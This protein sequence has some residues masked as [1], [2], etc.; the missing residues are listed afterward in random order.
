MNNLILNKVS[1]IK[2][3]FFLLIFFTSTDKVAASHGMGGEIT[4]MCQPNGS[5]IFEIKFYRDCNG[6]PGPGTIT[7]NTTVPGIPNIPCNF[8]SQTDLSNQGIRSDGITVCLNCSQ[9]GLPTPGLVQELVYRS[10]PIVLIGVPPSIGWVFFYGECCRNSNLTNISASGG[11]GYGYRAKM[12]PYQGISTQPCF[13]SSPYFTEPPA[14]IAC[15]GTH[16]EYSVNAIDPERDSL[17]YSWGQPLDDAGN[18]IPFAPPYGINNQLPSIPQDPLTLDSHTGI[19]SFTSLTGGYFITNVKVTAYKCGIKVAEVFRE[20]SIVLTNACPPVNGF[21]N[22]APDL[23]SP[24]IDPVTGL[25]TSYTDTVTAGDT[26]NFILY[27][28][29]FDLFNNGMNQTITLTG[30]SAQFGSGFLNPS[31]GC[32]MPPCATLSDSLPVSV[33]VGGQVAFN[34]VTTCD[35]LASNLPCVNEPNTYIFI[36]QAK[37]NFCPANARNIAVISITVVPI[38]TTVSIGNPGYTCLDDTLILVASGASSYIWNNGATGD[39]LIVT[40]PGTYFATALNTGTCTG[41]SELFYFYPGINMNVA[42]TAVQTSLCINWQ[43]T[44]LTGNPAG[45][46]WSGPGV[47]GS[48]FDPSLAGA[49]VHTVTYAVTDSLGCMGT[50]SFTINVDLC[51][52]IDEHNSPVALKIFPNPA[53]DMINIHFLGGNNIEPVVRLLNVYGQVMMDLNLNK[54]GKIENDYIELDISL[55]PKGIYFIS[56][57]GKNNGVE[58]FLKY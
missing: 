29:D 14:V 55:L 23:S 33:A 37:D 9:G 34:W 52:G 4:W 25:Q 46:T 8:Y 2:N 32:I 51:V 38:A 48:F 7:L 21:I 24:F 18:P 22:A 5:F 20:I 58:K 27:F 47:N 12:Y 11:I 40:Q 16:V 31:T 42:A 17:V 13:D 56:L 26:V 15:T 39:T 1:I 45:G 54:N 30:T 36:F 41:P 43:P 50:D 49:G 57:S 6:I 3:L 44:I 19:I 53:T 28:N 35:H 10:L